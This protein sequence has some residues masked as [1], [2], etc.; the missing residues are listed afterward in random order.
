[1]DFAEPRRSYTK[2]FARYALE[3]SRL[4]TIKDAAHHLG[5]SWDIV[6]DIQKQDL[7]R[8]FA[9]PKLKHL[10][11]IAI[12]EISVGKGHRYV[13]IVMDLKL[14]FQ[15]NV[16]FQPCLIRVASGSFAFFDELL[17]SGHVHPTTG[18]LVWQFDLC[19][20]EEL[21][22]KGTRARNIVKQWVAFDRDLGRA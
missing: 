3:L 20:V 2:S 9:K 22:D 1:V 5:V 6:K 16:R 17:P 10:R 19:G 13:T 18:D 11:Q 15:E 8:R 14:V 12:D 21:L 7:R 4:M